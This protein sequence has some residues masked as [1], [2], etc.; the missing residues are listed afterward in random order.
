MTD[1]T[2][3]RTDNNGEVEQPL[4][5]HLVELRDRLLRVVIFM[6]I[7]MVGLMLFASDL[8]FYFSLPIQ[9]YLP[10]GSSLVAIGTISPVFTPIKLAFVAS[11]FL[12]IPYI[13]H[14][15][16]GFIAPGLYQNE[17]RLAVPLLISSIILFY[18]GM[19]FAYLVV[20]P[21]V[22]QFT[23][24]FL[25]KGVEYLPDIADY[26]NFSIKMFFAFGVAFE[27]PIATILLIATGMTTPEKLAKKRPYIIVGA[28]TLGM[29]LTPPDVISQIM[30]ALPMWL[31]FEV[32][33]IAAKVLLK[34]RIEDIKKQEAEYAKED[35][36]SDE[37][38]DDELNKAIADEDEV[39]K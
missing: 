14:Q 38:M 35:A 2:T 37:E 32:G 30:L 33:I 24:S 17:K 8:Y 23:A 18:M 31:L 28:F 16:W 39:N 22:F 26:L 29:L 13:L 1:K 4:I 15:A 36:L 19:A 21:L 12:L 27:V 3:N 34:S 7:V 20:F 9:H 5:S 11:F 6:G 10:E 25:P